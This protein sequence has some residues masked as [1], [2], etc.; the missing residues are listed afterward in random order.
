MSISLTT[1]GVIRILC[2]SQLW[3][4]GWDK[5]DLSVTNGEYQ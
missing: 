2:H 4:V 5:D 1:M 3:R